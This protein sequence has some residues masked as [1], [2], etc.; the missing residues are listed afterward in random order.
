MSTFGVVDT[1]FASKTTEQTLAD[2]EA[3]ERADISDGLNL[4]AT[5]LLGQ[6]NG[7]FAAKLAELWDVAQAVYGAQFPA[8]ASGA[9]LDNVASLT[10]AIRLAATKSTVTLRVN[11]DA[12]TTLAIGRIV[13]IST[14]GVR[15][16]TTASV[17]NATA[18]PGDFSVAAEAEATGPTVANDGTFDT[19][20]TAVSGWT[21]QAGITAGNAE[22]YDLSGGETL[23]V[24]VDSGASQLV[25]F[26]GG[27][28]GTPGSATALEVATRINTDTTGLTAS[29]AGGSVRIESDTDGVG[30][31]IEIISG[32][33]NTVLGFSTSKIVGMNPSLAAT[34]TS[35]SSETYALSGGETLLVR[36]DGA[37]AT[38]VSFVG[39]DFAAPG[40][41]TAAEVATRITTDLTGATAYEISGTVRIESDSEGTNSTLEVTGGSA[42]S[43]LNFPTSPS[44]GS[45]GSAI[46]GRDLETDAAFRTRREQLL[47][48]AGNATLE[49]IRSAVRAVDNVTEAFVFENT[50]LAVDGD[51]LPPKSFEVV[52]Q[53]GTDE[54]IAQ[55]I[56]DSKPVGIETFGTTSDTVTDSQGVVHTIEFTRPT[57]I[58]I[59]FALTVVTNA[60]EFPADGEQQIIDALVALGDTLTI[61]E[62]VIAIAFRC[63]PLDIDGVTDVTVFLL[64]T[65]GPPV[66]TTN[67]AID[68]RELAD[69]D[70]S[71]I[72]VTVT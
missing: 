22:T 12:G 46:V 66:G 30:S 2:I 9:S 38:T 40:A 25:S 71:R 26:V 69:F 47:Q 21:A 37:A 64:D 7:I 32:D 23:T 36:V 1:G 48:A 45:D 11:L 29:D 55:T 44:G 31:A 57:L 61:G 52:V 54:D 72:T 10:G 3:D 33:A 43:V 70:P 6:I 56:F 63:V 62:D 59:H 17:T 68:T 20:V 53:G 19:I 50:T 5:S 42:A 15:F 14:S 35:A 13:S 34:L 39:G 4:L 41:A 27:D 65:S 16:T 28:F 60:N 49:A 67:I 58:D 18:D 51:G 24:Q 8:S